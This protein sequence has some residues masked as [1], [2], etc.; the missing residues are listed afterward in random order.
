M[1]TR[2]TYLVQY[3]VNQSS[4]LGLERIRMLPLPL[5]QDDLHE[6]VD[7]RYW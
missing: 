7:I 2:I 6:V 3:L 4:E 5:G 1:G